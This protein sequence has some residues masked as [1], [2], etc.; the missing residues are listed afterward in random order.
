MQSNALI[1]RIV[2][3]ILTD[4]YTCVSTTVR[5]YFHHPRKFCQGASR[6]SPSPESEVTTV[7]TSITKDGWISQRWNPTARTPEVGLFR[8]GRCYNV[9]ESVCV[10]L[11]LWYFR[12]MFILQNVLFSW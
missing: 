1:P 5:I 2:Q 9:Q 12:Y 10:F 6:H 7:V 4:V 8:A 3:C 11:L